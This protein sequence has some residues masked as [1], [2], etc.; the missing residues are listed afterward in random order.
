MQTSRI[1]CIRAIALGLGLALATGLSSAKQEDGGHGKEKKHK[2][3]HVAEIQAGS[4]FDDR[5]RSAAV[6]YYGHQS[7]AGRCPPGLAKKH[8]GCL[9]PGQAKKWQRG[10]VLARTVVYYPVPREVVVRIGVAPPGYR[11]VRVANDILLIAIG[12]QM[13]VDAI[14]DLMR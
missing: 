9:P 10:Q 14:E 7:A 4:Y 8:N 3:E 13:V 12:T 5:Q 11:Y 1:S 2:K 6:E